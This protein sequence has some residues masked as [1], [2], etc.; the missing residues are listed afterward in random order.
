[1]RRLISGAAAGLGAVF[2]ALAFTAAA[3]E[4]VGAFG[5]TLGE[6]A[7]TWVIQ[8][9]DRGGEPNQHLVKE[10]IPPNPD[11]GYAEGS[12]LV[13]V[14]LVPSS[15]Q[16]AKIKAIMFFD[17]SRA[18]AMRMTH[19]LLLLQQDLGLQGR[20][21]DNGWVI[22]DGARSMAGGCT[23]AGDLPLWDM[24]IT[25]TDSALQAKAHKELARK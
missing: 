18:C 8:R 2:V 3:G 24:E 17:N 7:P 12:Y 16:V 5:V 15:R 20:V 1:M 11:G 9:Q 10:Y 19:T 14:Y 25:A 4:I 22:Q 6:V 13:Y 23:Q 21:E